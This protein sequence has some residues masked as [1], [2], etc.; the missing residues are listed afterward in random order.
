MSNQTKTH[1][2]PE[3][4]IEQNQNISTSTPFQSLKELSVPL[5]L[6][7][8]VLYKHEILICGGYEER[9]C[10]SYHTLKN[11]YKFICEYPSD[12]DLI[13]HC[14]VK[15]VDNNKDKNEITLLSFGSSL[16]G[17]SKHTLIMKYV[18][19]WDNGNN[20][21]MN[22]PKKLKKSN[23]CNEWTPFTDNHN[24][25]IQIG[26]D[27]DDYTG[28]CA[29]IGGRSNNLLFITHSPNNISVY[30]LNTFQFIK[31]DTL[32]TDDYIEHHCFVSKSENDEEMTKKNK[33]N[34]E[35]LLFCKKTGLL[36]EY[37]EDSNTFQ[38]HQLPVCDNI[39]PFFHY[40]YVCINDVILFFGGWNDIGW[41]V[42]K[43]VHKYSIQENKW[44][45]F[46]NTL[47]SPLEGCVAILNEDDTY[48][49][50]IGGQNDKNTTVLTHMKTKVRV[51]DP[52]QLSKNEIKFVTQYWIRNLKIKLGWIDDFDKIIIRYS[53]KK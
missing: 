31:H 36:I 45:T 17:E 18:S 22:K 49:H 19:V 53:K 28:M 8:R 9:A 13:G 12:V 37:N 43:S 11:E 14:V 40:A 4:Q 32:P 30:D 2:P 47:P 39:A 50:I 46:Q 20:N 16:L 51:W 27:E 15:L 42:S 10:Y 29:V 44:T 6:S 3:R 35:M 24:N 5:Y 25:P 26:R 1:K 41:I 7:Q 52:S 38:F 48:I 23:N 34:N 21:K 33:K